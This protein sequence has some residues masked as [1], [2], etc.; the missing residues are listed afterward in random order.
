[1]TRVLALLLVLLSA[2]TALSQ[3]LKLEITPNNPANPTPEFQVVPSVFLGYDPIASDTLEY[4]DRAWI[5]RRTYPVIGQI[6]I[7]EQGWLENDRGRDLAFRDPGSANIADTTWQRN[8]RADL[9]KMDIRQKPVADSFTMKWILFVDPSGET[10][11]PDDKMTLNWDRN[12][13]PPI[14]RHVILA[15]RN[16]ETI[17]DMKSA[18]SVVIWGDSLRENGGSQNLSITLYYNQGITAGIEE[19]GS[20]SIRLSAYPNPAIS[21]S[22]ILLQLDQAE[23]VTLGIFDVQGR[24]VMS[25]TF[26]GSMGM[27]ELEIDR[28][29]LGLA[30]GVYFVRA[31]IGTGADQIIKTTSI[32]IQ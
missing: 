18:N 14:V 10:P 28:A 6:P 3:E 2:S 32:R 1:M 27:N 11:H 25:Q 31:T 26:V 19:R 30:S 24:E 17:I 9:S 23:Y 13:I 4:G 7:F 29:Q 15:Y 5:E 22:K 12:Q 16:G 8:F 21:H 20:N